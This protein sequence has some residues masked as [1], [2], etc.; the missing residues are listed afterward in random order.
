MQAAP[1][2]YTVSIGH[3]GTHVV[4]GAIYPLKYDLLDD[5]EPLA[6]LAGQSA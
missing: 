5:L 1:D 4:N 2:G 6:L 3:L